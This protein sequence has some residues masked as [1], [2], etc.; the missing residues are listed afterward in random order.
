MAG[1]IGTQARWTVTSSQGTVRLRR[2]FDY[3]VSHGGSVEAQNAVGEDDPV[4]WVDKPG[5][6]DITFE[7]YQEQG[8]PEVDYDKLLETKEVIQLT[9][10]IVGGLSFQYPAA[11]VSKKDE[12][13]D[14]DGKHTFTVEISALT[15]KRL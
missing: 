1:P 5:P 13:G 14:K 4:G 7:V 2:M 12:A 9:Q 11:R 15:R 8:K 6:R 3:K 10:E